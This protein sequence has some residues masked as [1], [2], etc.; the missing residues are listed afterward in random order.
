MHGSFVRIEDN[1]FTLLLRDH[2]RD[3]LFLEKSILDGS[4][5]PLMAQQSQF[6]LLLS[7]NPEFLSDV[8]GRKPHVVAIK[9]FKETIKHHQID[10]FLVEHP[11]T[12]SPFWTRMGD[13]TE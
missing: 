9:N 8:L 5:R 6:I 12:P 1:R 13:L 4:P 7:R 3:D 11:G 10:H 2:H